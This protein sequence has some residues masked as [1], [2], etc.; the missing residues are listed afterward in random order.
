MYYPNGEVCVNSGHGR[1]RHLTHAEVTK[2]CRV[3]SLIPA[4]IYTTEQM[5]TVSI[6]E[7]GST[8]AHA[9]AHSGTKEHNMR[10]Y[11]FTHVPWAPCWERRPGGGAGSGRRRGDEPEGD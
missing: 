1:R 11:V 3:H 8:H 7:G 4:C 5:N 6:P 9:H 2:L 10:N